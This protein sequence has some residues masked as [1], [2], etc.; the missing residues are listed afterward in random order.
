VNTTD[1]SQVFAES[2]A[3][4]IQDGEGESQEGVDPKC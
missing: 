2:E 4:E 3:F 1:Q